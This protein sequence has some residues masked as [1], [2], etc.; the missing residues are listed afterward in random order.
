LVEN[1]NGDREASTLMEANPAMTSTGLPSIRE[2]LVCVAITVVI[3][4]AIHEIFLWLFHQPQD[5]AQTRGV[6]FFCLLMYHVSIY[7]RAKRALP[8][9]EVTDLSPA[10]DC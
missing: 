2:W 8:Q 9:F 5:I 6:I 1:N 7:L 3:A 4:L 10:R